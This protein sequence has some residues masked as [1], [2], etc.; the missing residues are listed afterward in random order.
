MIVSVTETK[1]INEVEET[2]EDTLANGID[3][4][5]TG[6]KIVA[7]ETTESPEI[8]TTTQ[9]NLD[10]PKPIA[11]IKTPQEE[12]AALA[13]SEITITTPQTEPINISEQKTEASVWWKKILV[14][15]RQ[16]LEG[17][18]RLLPKEA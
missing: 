15:L 4:V 9:D 13:E 8:I 2:I 11:V 14:N 18:V 16:K 12:S 10:S 7:E 5:N 3:S 17:L 1:T 6:E